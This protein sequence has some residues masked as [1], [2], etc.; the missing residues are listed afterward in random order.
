LDTAP[1]KV[2][3]FVARLAPEPVCDDCIAERL[4]L[5]ARQHVSRQT[6]ELAGSEGFVRAKRPCSL[7]GETKL[8]IARP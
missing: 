3:A 2:R 6:R 7:C 5:P 8:V 4:E 1:D